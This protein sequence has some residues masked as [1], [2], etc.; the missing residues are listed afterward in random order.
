MI[1]WIGCCFAALFFG[2]GH[3]LWGDSSDEGSGIA[4][5]FYVLLSWVAVFLIVGIWIGKLLKKGS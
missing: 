2:I 4:L 1:Y 3:T 5:V